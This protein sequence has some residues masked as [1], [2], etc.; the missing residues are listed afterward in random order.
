[1]FELHF[2]NSK[3]VKVLEFIL[4]QQGLN[5]SSM[6]KYSFHL[7]MVHTIYPGYLYDV[8]RMWNNQSLHRHHN[9]FANIGWP[10]LSHNLLPDLINPN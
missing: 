1:M 2:S 5:N 7:K 8:A 6:T 4:V 3:E 9:S 10:D